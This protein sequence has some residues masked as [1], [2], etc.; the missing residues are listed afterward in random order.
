MNQVLRF[1]RDVR[2]EVNRVTWPTG[3]ETR[4]LTIMVFIL[5]VIVSVYLLLVDLGIA[6]GM[7]A[8]LGI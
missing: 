7:S 3:A 5:V 1:I 6:A 2:A 8:L 4:R